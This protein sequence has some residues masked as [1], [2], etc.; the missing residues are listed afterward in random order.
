MDASNAGLIHRNGSCQKK[1]QSQKI[2][3]GKSSYPIGSLT[4][5][6]HCTGQLVPWH[7]GR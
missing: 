2:N 6:I 4:P 3:F 1:F 7:L 5:A